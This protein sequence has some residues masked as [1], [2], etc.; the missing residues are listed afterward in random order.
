VIR[1]ALRQA[2]VYHIAGMRKEVERADRARLGANPEGLTPEQLL[3][4]YLM[5]KEV[6]EPRRVELLEAAQNVFDSIK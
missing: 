6:P 5:S 1:E 3:E 4:R 2:D